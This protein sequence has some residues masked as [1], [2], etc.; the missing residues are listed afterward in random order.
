MAFGAPT[1]DLEVAP[2]SWTSWPNQADTWPVARPTPI[3][4]L[5]QA[6]DILSTVLSILQSFGA[7]TDQPKIAPVT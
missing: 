5:Y 6:T 7:P 4:Y 3:Y 2:A 1:D